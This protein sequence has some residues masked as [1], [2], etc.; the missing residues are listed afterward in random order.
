VCWSCNNT[1][2]D[3]LKEILEGKGHVL[4]DVYNQDSESLEFLWSTHDQR[5][6]KHQITVPFIA[7]M[8]LNY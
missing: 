2:L 8:K 3:L 4:Y 6:T 7:N 5:A 1:A